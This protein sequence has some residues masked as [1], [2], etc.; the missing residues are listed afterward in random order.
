MFSLCQLSRLSWH[1]ESV[2]KLDSSLGLEL[3]GGQEQQKIEAWLDTFLQYGLN[4][5]M[6]QITWSLILGED[7]I[8][9]MSINDIWDCWWLRNPVA[10]NIKRYRSSPLLSP[11]VHDDNGRALRH[12]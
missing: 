7:L 2:F 10:V 11:P 9:I 5:I 12:D 8:N 4:E 3:P 1:E 6:I